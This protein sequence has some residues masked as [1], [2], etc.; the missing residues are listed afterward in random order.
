[1]STARPRVGSVGYVNAQPLTDTLDRDRFE[2]IED[3]PSAIARRLASGDLDVGLVPVRVL[4]D[5][6]ELR[7]LPGWCVGAHGPV[8]SVVIAAETPPSAWTELVLDGSS[9]TSV[10]LARL[11][12]QEGPLADQVSPDLVVTDGA[13]GDGPRRVGGTVAAVVIGDPARVLPAHLQRWDLGALW[14]EWTG[15]PFVFAVWAAREGLSGAVREALRKA[16]ADGVAGIAERY[17][18]DDRDYLTTYIRHRLDESALV[19]LREFAARAHRAGLVPHHT[20]A[21]LDPAERRRSRRD[22]D[23]VLSDAAGG[24]AVSAESLKALSEDV[25][26]ADLQLAG[27]MRRDALHDPT[28]AT[29]LW[30]RGV[31]VALDPAERSAWLDTARAAGVTAITLC[32]DCSVAQRMAWIRA[33]RAHGLIPRA[34]ALPRG[35]VASAR[36]L[37]DLEVVPVEADLVDGMRMARWTAEGR[38]VAVHLDLSDPELVSRLVALQQVAAAHPIASVVAHLPLPEGALVAPGRVTP[39]AWLRGV[40]LVRLALPDVAHVVA[41]PATQ[42]LAMAQAALL[43]GAD[44]LGVVGPQADGRGWPEGTARFEG[45][46]G[47][48]ERMIRA[49]GMVPVRRTPRFEVAG[50]AITTARRVRPVGERDQ[51]AVHVRE[52]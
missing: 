15:R 6:P 39:A 25:S 23:T 18:G 11:L 34:D 21:L 14:T 27:R 32:G 24:Q 35:E 19:G 9:R 4:L 43:A 3:V 41:S 20:I 48:A 10:T 33:V 29:W 16:G 46:A 13:P 42:G 47:E 5:H 28:R 31:D 50:E 51:S 2:V 36:I 12:I 26:G 45:D 52:V 1:M 40:A 37:P 44:D 38:A 7:V 30:S 49:A 22:L 17:E 8:H